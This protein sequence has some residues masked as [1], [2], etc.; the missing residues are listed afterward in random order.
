MKKS[1]FS[2]VIPYKLRRL[3]P[4]LGLATATIFTGCDK[5]DETIPNRDVEIPFYNDNRTQATYF[6]IEQAAAQPDVRYIYLVPQGTWSTCVEHNIQYLRNY[7]LEPRMQVSDKVRG[8]GNFDFRVGAASKIPY[9]SLWYV[10]HGWTINAQL[11][12]QK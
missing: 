4:M 10:N 12:N 5:D 6:Q 2:Q 1:T 3:I 7:W 9:D 8:R 11:Q